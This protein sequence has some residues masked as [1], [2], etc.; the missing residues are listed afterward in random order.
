MSNTKGLNIKSIDILNEIKLQNIDPLPLFELKKHQ[1]LNE[2]G[3]QFVADTII[4]KLIK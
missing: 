1:H 3:Y 4:K 2:K